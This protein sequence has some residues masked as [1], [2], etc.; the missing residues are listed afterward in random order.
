MDSR[1]RWG[2]LSWWSTSEE[3][4]WPLAAVDLRKVGTIGNISVLAKKTFESTLF[5][6]YLEEAGGAECA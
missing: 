3:S 6:L 5:P 1:G 4:G 2:C